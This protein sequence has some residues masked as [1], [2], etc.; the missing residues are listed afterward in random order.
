MARG[1]GCSPGAL[2]SYEEAIERNRNKFNVREQAESCK[3]AEA[4]RDY[5]DGSW[6]NPNC[7]ILCKYTICGRMNLMAANFESG[8]KE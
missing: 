5:R 7:G 3:M 2:A 8:L 1:L 6:D 4:Y